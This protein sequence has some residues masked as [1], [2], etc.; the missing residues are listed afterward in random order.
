MKLEEI[1]SLKEL[2]NY[3]TNHDYLEEDQ[4]TNTTG[5]QVNILYSDGTISRTEGGDQFGK[6]DEFSTEYNKII[7]EK[8]LEL[9]LKY[10]IKNRTY[11]ILKDNISNIHNKIKELYQKEK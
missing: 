1:N 4:R 9:K 7:S 5:K 8:E 3:L 11:V 2:S 10:K 6:Q